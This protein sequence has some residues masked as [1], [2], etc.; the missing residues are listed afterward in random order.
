MPK[1]GFIMGI[2]MK[3]KSMNPKGVLLCVLAIVECMHVF[4]INPKV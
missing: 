3:Q 2:Y 4:T 1:M